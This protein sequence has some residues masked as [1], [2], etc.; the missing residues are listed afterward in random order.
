LF[1]ELKG[2][3]LVLLQNE[4]KGIS[5]IL[6]FDESRGI[7]FILLL[8]ELENIGIKTHCCLGNKHEVNTFITLYFFFLGA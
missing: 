8:D 4:S 1:G 3:G 6:L 7:K 5:Y 2:I